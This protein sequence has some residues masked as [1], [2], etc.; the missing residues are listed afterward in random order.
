MNLQRNFLLM[1]VNVFSM[2]IE[3]ENIFSKIII[4]LII[5][6]SFVLNLINIL[7]CCF[8]TIIFCHNT[9]FDFSQ[10]KLLGTVSMI[11]NQYYFFFQDMLPLINIR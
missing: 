5:T 1:Y 11:S 9:R 7:L 3:L 4:Y 2:H 6:R 8:K 10:S